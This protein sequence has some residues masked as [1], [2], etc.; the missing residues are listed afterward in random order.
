MVLTH[1]FGADPDE[2]MLAAA[3][4]IVELMVARYGVRRDE[5]YSL[6]SV[7]VDL[8]ITQVVV[9]AVGCD[10]ALDPSTFNG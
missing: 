10:A 4:S 6:A 8:G 5:A 7:E 9:G 3:R 1:G 2:A